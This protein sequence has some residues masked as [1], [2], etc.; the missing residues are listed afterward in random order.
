MLVSV[1]ARFFIAALGAIVGCSA[2]ASDGEVSD[3]D[4]AGDVLDDTIA[5]D[6]SHDATADTQATDSRPT[7]AAPDAAVDTHPDIAPP[8]IDSIPWVTGADVGFGVARKDAANPAGEN[9][10]LAYG[11]Y[12]VTL[13][14]SEAWATELY[15][16]TLQARGVRWIWAVQGP[17]DPSYSAKEIGNSKIIAAMLPHVGASTKFV[18]AVGH[19][20]GSFVAHELLGQLAGG[21]DPS[22]VTKDRVVYFDLDGGTSGLDASIVG[23]LRRGYFVGSWD[24]TISTASPNDADMRAGGA[25]YASAGGYWQND[26]SGSG[27]DAGAR[28]CVHMTL[29]TTRPHDPAAASPVD[30]ADFAGRP[31]AHAYLEAK[32]T[33]AGLHP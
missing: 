25:T 23:R 15:R 14:Q 16:A 3:A 7:D 6:A 29:I 26:A 18:L 4:D 32:A 1:K 28:W 30:Y 22:D 27:C 20:S 21:L 12:N 31:V 13:E 17:A 2:S 33:E 11:G 5:S 10:F 8:D 24:A 9:V 19:S